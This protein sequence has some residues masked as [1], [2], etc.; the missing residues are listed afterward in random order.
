MKNIKT[1]RKVRASIL[2][3]K[4]K[5]NKP[6]DTITIDV[7]MNI[8]WPVDKYAQEAFKKY[9]LKVKPNRATDVSFDVTGKKQDI[10]DY[11]GSE[12]YEWDDEDIRDIYPEL[13]EASV[14]EGISAGIDKARRALADGKKVF[15]RHTH[16]RLSGKEFEILSFSPT[17]GMAEV[18]W[19]DGKKPEDMASFSIDDRKIRIEE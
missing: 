5:S 6:N 11:L 7:D 10:I 13:L 16:P 18:M 4:L 14:N 8:D 15:G 12:Y 3:E 2:N 1:F 17:G 9:K 19:P